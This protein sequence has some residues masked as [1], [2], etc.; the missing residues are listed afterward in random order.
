MFPMK[1]SQEPETS[2]APMIIPKIQEL[3]AVLNAVVGVYH[4]SLVSGVW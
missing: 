2:S 3:C 4:C 1:L